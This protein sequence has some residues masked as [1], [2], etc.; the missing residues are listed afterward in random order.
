MSERR[1]VE[2]PIGVFDSGVGGLTVLA[3]LMRELPAEDFVY[4][5]HDI[6]AIEDDRCATRRSQR[7]MEHRTSF[8]GVDSLSA[9]H[10][11]D[12]PAQATGVS[13]THVLCRFGAK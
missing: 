8:S 2:A 6:A 13:Q 7:H 11:L 3:A 10:R 5:G 12:A 1:A 4:L 9:E